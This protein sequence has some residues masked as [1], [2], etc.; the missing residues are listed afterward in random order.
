[1]APLHFNILSQMFKVVTKINYKNQKNLDQLLNILIHKKRFSISLYTYQKIKK[2]E[3]RRENLQWKRN[4]YLHRRLTTKFLQIL[5]FHYLKLTPYQVS[6]KVYS[7]KEV[8]YFLNI[9]GVPNTEGK[10]LSMYNL[11]SFTTLQHPDDPRSYTANKST[12]TP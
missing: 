8:G 7:R 10:K 6:K 2:G 5:K 4:K 1:M 9:R 12:M 11:T 3:K